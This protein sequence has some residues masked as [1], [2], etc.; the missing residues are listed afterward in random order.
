M[1]S[2]LVLAADA[3]E[4]ATETGLADAC[5]PEPSNLCENVFDWTDVRWLATSADDVMPFVK[6]III[7]TVGWMAQRIVR[8]FIRRIVQG[9]QA[10]AVQRSLSSLRK[11]TPRAFQSTSQHVTL[12]R[13]QR[14]ETI[15]AILRSASTV[16]IFIF[17]FF[18]CLG[19]FSFDL[20]PFIAGT[21]IA[22][23]ALGFGAQNIV[24]DFLAGFFIV[25]EDQ[26]GV[27]DVIDTGTASGTV[28]SVSLRVTR[29][30][31]TDGT[32]WHVPNGEMKKVGN[33][34]QTWSRALVEL[35]VM[36]LTDIP[37]AIEV[38]TR[39]ADDLWQDVAYAGLMTA[40]PEIWAPDAIDADGILI[41]VAIKTRPKEQ[42]RIARTLRSRIKAAFDAEGIRI[43]TSLPDAYPDA[44]VL[45]QPDESDG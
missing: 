31:S 20:G 44:K 14:A 43:A 19:Q 15:G 45:Q 4:N 30:R 23:A 35:R 9:L 33:M 32:L 21:A 11:R 10:D 5:G 7:L 28:E 42:W 13:A 24:R 27:G 3:T 34:S 12:R 29:M 26:Y 6:V 40:E 18:A 1:T 39:V 36:P 16:I 2:A 17:V 22:T 25:V 38:V 41:K 8:R 37:K